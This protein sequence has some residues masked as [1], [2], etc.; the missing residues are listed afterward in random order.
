MLSIQ[1]VGASVVRLNP[2]HSSH[3]GRRSPTR[4]HRTGKASL[5][6]PLG[7]YTAEFQLQATLQ[8]SNNDSWLLIMDAVGHA[9]L[10]A[11][12]ASMG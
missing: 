4:P 2:D 6:D 9:E 11:Y 3:S 10:T 5:D 12:A 1:L 7:A 8:E